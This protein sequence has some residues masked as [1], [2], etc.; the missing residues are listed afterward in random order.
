MELYFCLQRQCLSWKLRPVVA[1]RIVLNWIEQITGL[2]L[3]QCIIRSNNVCCS[4]FFFQGYRLIKVTLF[5]REHWSVASVNLKQ[6]LLLSISLALPFL[7]LTV[8]LTI[9]LSAFSSSLSPLV[10]YFMLSLS[11][12]FSPQNSCSHRLSWLECILHGLLRYIT[13]PLTIWE[14]MGRNYI[15]EN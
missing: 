8:S 12:P 5:I 15:D 2:H 7:P 14:D 6:S 13:L 9:F 10:F 1:Q 11:F 4:I 3:A